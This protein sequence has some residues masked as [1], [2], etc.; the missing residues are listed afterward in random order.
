MK[1][2]FSDTRSS[3]LHLWRGERAGQCALGCT[4][5]LISFPLKYTA[6]ILM[7]SYS[8]CWDRQKVLHSRRI[9]C[10]IEK[11]SLVSA[12]RESNVTK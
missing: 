3:V 2:G 1:E 10:K 12:I 7:F 9:L 8:I 5:K 11:C 6:R 4:K